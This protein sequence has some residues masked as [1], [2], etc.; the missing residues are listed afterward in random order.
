MRLR[1][2]TATVRRLSVIALVGSARGEGRACL[3]YEVSL[4]Y[5]AFGSGVLAPGDKSTPAQVGSGLFV[6]GA[7]V[8]DMLSAGG[9]GNA[10]QIHYHDRV[11]N[12]SIISLYK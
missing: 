11:V 12:S 7:H 9:V 4:L 5:M 8:L 6:C 3:S 1:Q 2:G 10:S